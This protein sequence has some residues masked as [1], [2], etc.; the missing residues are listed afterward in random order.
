MPV[1]PPASRRLKL[2]LEYSGTRY[3]GWQIQPNAATVQGTLE[4]CL[5]RLTNGP[6]RLHAAGR[7]DAGVH[8]LGQV[9]HF[10][11]T[12]TIVLPALVRGANSLL[13]S[14]IVVRQA[15]DVPRHFHA[16]YSARRKTYAYIVHNH[17]VPSAFR[18]PYAWHVP[19]ALALP[20]MRA[21]ARVLLGHHDFSAFR[22][23][24]CTAR[25]PWRRLFFLRIVRHANR[26]VFVLN[27]DGF[28]QH[29]VRT[30]VGTL[31][32]IGRAQI[33]ADAMA[34]IL[35]S[36]QRRYAGATAPAHG[37][38]LVRVFYDTDTTVIA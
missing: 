20:A 38:F 28:L 8:A 11:T 1:Q 31:V 34:T 24:S 13:P 4:A 21:A 7:T 17:S 27:A 10:D 15:E 19:Q 30:I 18:F 2:L 33:P 6:V 29:M 36:G 25:D 12:S 3:H 5:A 16:R 22:A 37:L 9:A 35:Q 32:A 14:D 26:L 23:A